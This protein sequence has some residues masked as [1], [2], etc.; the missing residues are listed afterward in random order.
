MTSQLS[1]EDIRD[2]GLYTPRVGAWA[3]D[4]YKLVALY[5]ALFSTGM[6]DKWDLRVY[7]DLCAG[8]GYAKIKGTSRIVLSSP[9]IALNVQHK[10]DKY[11]F[12][13]KTSKR[14]A[15]LKKRVSMHFPN[16]DVEYVRGDCNAMTAEILSKIPQSINKSVLCLCFIDPYNIGIQFDTIKKLAAERK[17]DFL[18][19]LPTGMDANR[20]QARY[21]SKNDTKI[22]QFL[23][24]EEW[25]KLLEEAEKKGI[26]FRRFLAG[27]Y[28]SQISTLGYM[29]VPISKMKEIRSDE[30]NLPLYHL[31]LFSKNERGYDFGGKVLKDGTAQQSFL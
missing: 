29:S 6:K 19:V 8:A 25:R 26:P 21:F 28:G 10:F 13:E 15:A 20:N 31:A 22:A 18:I 27:L 30:K 1:A 24:K 12:C 7:I 2:D 17:M 16:A 14:L 9:L 3:E 4:K 23:G 5:D 11:I